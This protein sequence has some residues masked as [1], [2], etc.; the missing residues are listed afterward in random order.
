LLSALAVSHAMLDPVAAHA[1]APTPMGNTAPEV[2]ASYLAG[3]SAPFSWEEAQ[4]LVQ[5]SAT[6]AS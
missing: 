1:L 5:L 3:V 6:P 4:R 2:D